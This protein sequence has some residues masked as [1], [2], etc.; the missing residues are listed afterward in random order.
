MRALS[1][2]AA[3]VIGESNESA[4]AGR[5]GA[6]DEVEDGGR[7]EGANGSRWEWEK[8]VSEERSSFCARAHDE[9]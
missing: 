3:D 9:H 7:P 1:G 2:T 5:V 6:W 8:G 4:A